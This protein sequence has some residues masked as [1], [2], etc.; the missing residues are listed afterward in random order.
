MKTAFLF[1]GQGSQVVGMGKDICE[2]YPEANE[3][4]EKASKILGQD[5]KALCFE[6]DMET[7]SQTKNTQIALAVTSLAILEVLKSKGIEAEIATG[8]SL[9]EYVALMYAGYLT[10]EDGLKK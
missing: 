7:L 5:M 4:F 1:P 6:S 9:G 2:K 10:L 3:V 8:L